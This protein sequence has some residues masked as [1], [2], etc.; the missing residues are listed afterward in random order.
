MIRSEL[1]KLGFYITDFDQSQS[2]FSA[3]DFDVLIKSKQIIIIDDS[4]SEPPPSNNSV[5]ESQ[6]D[7]TDSN[8]LRENYKPTLIKVL[9]IAESPPAGGTFFY[10]K[11]SNLFRCIRDAFVNVFG[12]SLIDSN[13][14]LNFF[15]TNN[16]YLDDLCLEPVND[17]SDSERIILRQQGVEPLA[18]R[19][20]SHNPDA[21]IILMKGIETEVKAAIKQ[22]TKSIKY[23]YT[24]PF[25]SF[26]NENK[27][28]CITENESI[29]KKLIS[30]TILSA[31]K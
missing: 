10:A 26:S 19:I 17:K 28:N 21:I 30:S 20:K 11:N 7:F 9:Y 18:Q 29:L 6:D 4:S 16:F 15:K 23:I 1:R 12:E 27:I 22:S 14:F 25:P 8:R 24:T 5:S 2:G 13:T 31:S 3:M